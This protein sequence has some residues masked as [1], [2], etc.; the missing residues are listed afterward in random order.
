[1]NVRAP[2]VV[3]RRA[4]LRRRRAARACAGSQCTP[5]SLSTLH[6]SWVEEG[7][8]RGG[9]YRT[10]HTGGMVSRTPLRHRRLAGSCEPSLPPFACHSD[11]CQTANQRQKLSLTSSA[12]IGPGRPFDPPQRPTEASQRQ[13]LL[14]FVFSQDVAHAGQERPVPD[15]CQRL[16]PLSVMAGFQVSTNGPGGLMRTTQHLGKYPS[17]GFGGGARCSVDEQTMEGD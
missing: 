14:S 1:M 17:H 5:T 15:R 16:G 11:L 13:D 9:S 4:C 10:L 8:P 12:R 7:C 3:T 2:N 6:Q